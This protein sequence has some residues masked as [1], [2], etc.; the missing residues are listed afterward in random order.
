MPGPIPFP[1]DIFEWLCE[2]N[3]EQDPNS[4]CE[5]E[6]TM[7][8]PTPNKR[9]RHSSRNLNEDAD[10]TPRPA[11][12]LY[13]APSTTASLPST[14]TDSRTSSPTKQMQGLDLMKEGVEW[15]QID[16]HSIPITV[17]PIIRRLRKI[18]KCIHM[19]PRSLAP[20]LKPV[21]RDAEPNGGDDD[22]DDDED[23]D[24][25]R[26]FSSSEQEH[27]ISLL[28]GRIPESRLL[29]RLVSRAK[30]LRDE[31]HEE[32]AWNAE[33]HSCLLAAVFRPDDYDD[34]KSKSNSPTRNKNKNPVADDDDGESTPPPPLPPLALDFT[35]ATTAKLHRDYKPIGPAR[36]KMVDFVVHIDPTTEGPETRRR[37]K[38]LRLATGTQSVN[39]T[40]FNPLAKKPIVISIETKKPDV[41]SNQAQLQ[42]GMWHAC[43][44]KFLRTHA[45]GG[46]EALTTLGF[47][48]GIVIEGHVWSF[49]FSTPKERGDDDDDD[50]DD[51]NGEDE[52]NVTKKTVVWRFQRMGSTETLLGTYQIVSG[53]RFLASW[54]ET[55]YWP[56]FRINVLA[57]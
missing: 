10:M 13:F 26:I 44:W 27:D 22:V 43:H 8:L 49:V 3:E 40:S 48:P 52:G 1:P 23:D 6:P 16:M 31:D 29:Q 25:D 53:L 41:G 32:A 38:Q 45:R 15:R 24:T 36:S 2:V 19:L 39:P 57:L 14:M 35:F 42:V 33:V 56:W 12:S 51:G 28:P 50:D 54:A 18:D 34:S 7:T 30:R 5:H 20:L 47:L 37:I 11:H 9:P 17:R 4:C 21:L 46:P 55:K